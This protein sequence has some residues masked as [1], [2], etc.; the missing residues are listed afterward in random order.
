MIDVQKWSRPPTELFVAKCYLSRNIYW[1]LIYVPKKL[2]YLHIMYFTKVKGNHLAECVAM[3]FADSNTNFCKEPECQERRSQLKEPCIQTERIEKKSWWSK[4]ITKL[5][6]FSRIHGD[7]FKTCVLEDTTG[8]LVCP[9]TPRL[10][11]VR[12]MTML[13]VKS[14]PCSKLLLL[15]NFNFQIEKNSNNELC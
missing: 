10:R 12:N 14:G 1:Y 13:W 6:W 9:T 8:F 5:H 2:T 15:M 7:I 11:R 3:I 4:K